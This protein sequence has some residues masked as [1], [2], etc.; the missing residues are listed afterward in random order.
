MIAVGTGPSAGGA[1]APISDIL[2]HVGPEVKRLGVAPKEVPRGGYFRLPEG[3]CA[4]STL[5]TSGYKENPYCNSNVS[6]G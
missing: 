6:D 5:N 4:I 1:R 3:T 2:S